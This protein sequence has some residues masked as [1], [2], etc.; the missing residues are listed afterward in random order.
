M[1]GEGVNF[2]T[3]ALSVTPLHLEQRD[4]DHAHLDQGETI[5]K[6]NTIIIVTLVWHKYLHTI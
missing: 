5:I 1:E 2:I 6:C 3:T 4:S